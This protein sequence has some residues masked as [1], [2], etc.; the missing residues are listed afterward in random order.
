MKYEPPET[1]I[2]QLSPFAFNV[3]KDGVILYPEGDWDEWS[4]GAHGEALRWW[5]EAYDGSL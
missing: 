3:Y 4:C 1:R 2:E 5:I